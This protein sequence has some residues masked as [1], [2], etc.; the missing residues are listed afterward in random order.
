MIK[1]DNTLYLIGC[2]KRTAK[3][4]YI[5]GKFEMSQG[6]YPAASLL[7]NSVYGLY[8]QIKCAFEI[9]LRYQDVDWRKEKINTEIDFCVKRMDKLQK[10]MSECVEKR[11]R[12]MHD[13][14]NE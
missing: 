10:K 4:D 14:D 3:E 12:A 6:N 7:F 11:I 2:L 5:Q 1:A 13:F 9:L 8:F